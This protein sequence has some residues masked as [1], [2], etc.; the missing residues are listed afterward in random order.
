MICRPWKSIIYSYQFYSVF[1]GKHP[2]QFILPASDTWSYGKYYTFYFVIFHF[3]YF[4]TMMTLKCN[5]ADTYSTHQWLE[6]YS[7]S[8]SKY[9]LDNLQVLNTVLS[10]RDTKT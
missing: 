1:N 7:D 3:F 10:T 6:R 4:T 8:T 2:L 9:L 5:V